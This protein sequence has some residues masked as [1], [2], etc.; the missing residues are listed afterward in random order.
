MQL[1]I[2]IPEDSIKVAT[3]KAIKIMREVRDGYLE[4]G[5]Y[6]FASEL[7]TP[8]SIK[9]SPANSSPIFEP[10][11]KPK[12]EFKRTLS[13]K[14]SISETAKLCDFKTISPR[15]KSNSPI[16]TSF[17][18]DFQPMNTVEK[19]FTSVIKALSPKEKQNLEI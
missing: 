7:L 11:P 5:N 2:K 17:V 9:S 4:E 6:Q 16:E 19:L 15:K 3:M 13:W 14:D 12:K 1:T 18:E 8:K 10:P